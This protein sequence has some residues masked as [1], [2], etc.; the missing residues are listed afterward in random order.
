MQYLTDWR[1]TLARDLL[2]ARE[3]PIDEIAAQTGYSTV[4]A[5][6]TAFRRHHGAP[7]RRWQQRELSA[8]A[9]GS[10]GDGIHP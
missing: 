10:A 6:A 7:P 2:L 3:V 4:Y 1:M 5:F 8:V 9:A